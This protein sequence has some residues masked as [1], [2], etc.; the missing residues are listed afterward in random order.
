M[1]TLQIKPIKTSTTLFLDK[2]NI[3]NQLKTTIHIAIF[4]H[5]VVG[6]ALINQILEAAATIEK[7]KGFKL[8]IFAIANSRKLLLNSNGIQGNW[9]AALHTLGK[10]YAI[11][12]VF[13]F[14]KK[15]NL[16]N[17]IAIDNTASDAFTANYIPFILNDF[18]LISS[19]KIANT[20]S[21]SFYKNFHN[22]VTNHKKEYRYETNV[23]AGLPIIDTIKLLHLS[24][25]NITKISGFSLGH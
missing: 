14:A 25:E 12:D 8:V 7:R 15:N 18:D 1:E 10:T 5:G 11:T 20:K 23:G 17:L 6:G 13:S 2:K 22:I 19:N 16:T 24:G 4:G 9:E 3:E 21:Y